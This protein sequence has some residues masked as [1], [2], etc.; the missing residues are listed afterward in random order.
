MPVRWVGTQ[1]QMHY[2]MLVRGRLPCGWR[3]R[4][5]RQLSGFDPVTDYALQNLRTQVSRSSNFLLIPRTG[6]V[7]I[8]KRRSVSC[9]YLQKVKYQYIISCSYCE[10]LAQVFLS[11][12]FVTWARSILPCRM[13]NNHTGDSPCWHTVRS[14]AK[15]HPDFFSGLD[16]ELSSLSSQVRT[17]GRETVSS[18]QW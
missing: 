2:K 3:K 14:S 9:Y 8:V 1:L 17:N 6:T 5:E 15:L 11:W 4:W 7:K 10:T 12:S 18:S 16:S 13:W